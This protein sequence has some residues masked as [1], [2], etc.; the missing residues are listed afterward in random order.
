[1]HSP[2]TAFEYIFRSASLAAAVLCLAALPARGTSVTTA[3]LF[4]GPAAG[5]DSV[6]LAKKLSAKLKLHRQRFVASW[7]ATGSCANKNFPL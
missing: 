5:S 3:S 2:L 4:E 6:T 1:M 7:G